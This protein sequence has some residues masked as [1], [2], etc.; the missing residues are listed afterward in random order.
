V[1]PDVGALQELQELQ[2]LLLNC[3]FTATLL[4]LYCC[5]TATIGSCGRMWARCSSCSSCR[6][7]RLELRMY[8]AFGY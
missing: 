1:R 7:V 8:V 2:V 4:L 5:F 3:C 6:Q